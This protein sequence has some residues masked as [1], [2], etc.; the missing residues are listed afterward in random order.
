MLQEQQQ[1]TLAKKHV[2]GKER[3]DFLIKQTEFFTQFL[4]SQRSLSQSAAKDP[5][6]RQLQKAILKGKDTQLKESTAASKRKKKA[7]Y[8]DDASNDAEEDMLAM[9]RLE[10]QPSCL[11]GGG[12]LRDYQLTSLN[13]LIGLYESGING[14][15]ADEMVSV[16]RL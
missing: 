2:T 7:K 16:K 10:S 14:I 5:E 6:L 4:I 8:G 9:T 11:R 13:W 3:L 15:L 12:Q 1:L